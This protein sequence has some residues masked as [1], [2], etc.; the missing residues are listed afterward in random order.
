MRKLI[1]VLSVLFIGFSLLAQENDLQKLKERADSLKVAYGEGDSR[2]MASLD[3]VVSF[4]VSIEDYETALVYREKKLRSLESI[5]QENSLDYG[6][7][8][9]RCSNI[10][11]A[12]NRPASDYIELCS[13]G[14]ELCERNGDNSSELYQIGVSVCLNYYIRIND[15]TNSERY[16]ERYKSFINNSGDEDGILQFGRFEFRVGGIAQEKQNWDSAIE[17]YSSCMSILKPFVNSN[18]KI[19]TELYYASLYIIAVD[20]LIIGDLEKSKECILSYIGEVKE[21]DGENNKSYILGLNLLGDNAYAQRDY[22][23]ALESYLGCEN[24]IITSYGAVSQEYKRI[25]RQI[26]SAYIGLSDY[27]NA[28]ARLEICKSI[29]ENICLQ[30]TIPLYSNDEYHQIVSSLGIY[31]FSCGDYQMSLFYRKLLLSLIEK[32]PTHT[33]A[34]ICEAKM[35]VFGVLIQLESYVEADLLRIEIND[36]I[37]DCPDSQALS[38]FLRNCYTLAV[39]SDRYQ[40]AFELSRKLIEQAK[41]E[42]D[43]DSIEYASLL[44]DV[45]TQYVRMGYFSEAKSLLDEA[46]DFS[47]N[48]PDIYSEYRGLIQGVI[49]DAYAQMYC[50]SDITKALECIDKSLYLLASSPEFPKAYLSALVTKG[51]IF[52]HSQ[53][54]E[55]ALTVFKEAKSLANDLKLNINSPTLTIINMNIAIT[56]ILMGDYANAIKL[57]EDTRRSISQEYG[58]NNYL[59]LSLL[60]G[61]AAYYILVGK[62][63]QSINL[64]KEAKEISEILYGDDNIKSAQSSLLLGTAYLNLHNY[65]IAKI[66]VEDALMTLSKLNVDD[67]LLLINGLVNIGTAQL[68]SGNEQSANDSFNRAKQLL[69]EQKFPTIQAEASLYEAELYRAIGQAYGESKNVKAIN[70]LEHSLN[71]FEQIG[72]QNHPAY[73]DALICLS[74]AYFGASEK[75]NP[76][77]IPKINNAFKSIYSSNIALF[78]E[79]ERESYLSMYSDLSDTVFSSR[80]D[81]TFDGDLYDFVLMNKGLLLGTANTFYKAILNSGDET[82]I[83]DLT[84]MRMLNVSIQKSAS[85]TNETIRQQ[86]DSLRKESAKIER[87]LVSKSKDYADYSAWVASTW[88]DIQTN[89]TPKDVAIEFIAYNNVMDGTK[90]YAALILKKGM[91]RPQFVPICDLSQ[92]EDFINESPDV[93]YGDIAISSQFYK[94]FWMPIEEYLSEGDT[95]Y[96]SPSDF[97]QTFALESILNK[98]GIS[99]DKV[100]SFNRVSSTKNIIKDNNLP[101]NSAVVYGGLKYDVNVDEMTTLS[102]E[103]TGRYSLS[104]AKPQYSSDYTR[105]G[106]S[107]LPG[108][109]KETDVIADIL[110]K[111]GVRCDVR[112]G[113]VGNEESFK[114]LSGSKFDI[115]HIATHGFFIPAAQTKKPEY[116]LKLDFSGMFD[117]SNASLPDINSPMLRSGLLLSGAN[118]AWEG[119]DLPEEIEDGILTSSEIASCNFIGTELVVLSACET[120]L[121]EITSEGVFGLQRAFKMAGAKTIIMSLWKVDDESTRLMMTTLYE[122]LL[123][124]SSKHDAFEYAKDV[125]KKKYKSPY[126]W[127]SFIMLD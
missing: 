40:E 55:E 92:I 41:Q 84:K 13:A 7:T 30:E 83:N 1:V 72:V 4:A 26:S 73:F 75:G 16:L 17:H 38:Y 91:A 28:I 60:N 74:K 5:K 65:D 112:Q 66:Y 77:L 21:Y 104:Y 50:G 2:Y 123:S 106:W 101:F 126:Y 95:I 88:K 70:F 81:D 90:K 102:K 114:S 49:F 46:L 23:L 113:N 27:T 100:Y 25:E 78:S 93:I 118:S 19:R 103:Y 29:I 80:K 31:Y 109:K 124:G 36:R 20:Y 59:Y 67:S 18:E 68:L 110:K 69:I 119:K 89:L 86:A 85:S 10:I 35:D 71:A 121:G 11:R 120:G 34:E 48:L 63:E 62:F 54:P 37:D 82:S 39:N 116:L 111:E 56:N 79:S 98:D 14:V 15:I 96:Y 87:D 76:L 51:M 122:K 64:L 3:D 6:L 32:N 8:L 53:V 47:N 127:A 22:K 115:L 99:I 42:K 97:L 61:E 44:T 107:Y 12:M 58:I 43:T 57:F 125:V 45:A 108:T 33:A 9:I 24:W 52:A 105:S 117:S 94:T